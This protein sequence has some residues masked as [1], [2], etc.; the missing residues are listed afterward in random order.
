MEELIFYIVY[1]SHNSGCFFGDPISVHTN[2]Q[3]AIQ[4]YNRTKDM[5]NY[6][7]NW[8]G[9]KGNKMFID[10]RKNGQICRYCEKGKVKYF[11]RQLEPLT[12]D[13]M[14]S[15]YN[16]RWYKNNVFYERK[17]GGE[18]PNEKQY[19][20]GGIDELPSFVGNYPQKMWISFTTKIMDDGWHGDEIFLNISLRFT[21]FMPLS[22]GDIF[23][24]YSEMITNDREKITGKNVNKLFLDSCRNSPA[25]LPPRKIEWDK[26]YFFES[27]EFDYFFKDYPATKI[28]HWWKKWHNFRRWKRA[29]KDV[30]EELLFSPYLMV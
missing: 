28:Q 6:E 4:A 2:K 3:T 24:Y 25:L 8:C 27:V 18:Y 29:V 9:H 16:N 26:G 19:Y 21:Q 23:D 5:W 15:E 22:M 17:Y 11:F 10:H 20:F 7:C 30:H 12:L 13:K 14:L 1:T